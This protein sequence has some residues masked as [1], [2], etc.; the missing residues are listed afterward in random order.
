VSVSLSPSPAAVLAACF[1]AVP[2]DWGVFDT[3]RLATAAEMAATANHCAECGVEMLAKV[4]GGAVAGTMVGRRSG[5]DA[6]WT[7]SGP[8][9]YQCDK[10]HCIAD[11]Y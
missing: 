7:W 6:A 2:A 5:A 11:G 8:W 9:C 4:G 10:A 1:E 3:C